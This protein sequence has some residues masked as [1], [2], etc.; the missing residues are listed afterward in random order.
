MQNPTLALS[1]KARAITYTGYALLGVA[2][3]AVQV[4]FAAAEQ[5]QPVWLTVAL[6]VYA[7]VGG[8]V[9]FTA[10]SHTP[11]S[12]APAVHTVYI[13]ESTPTTAANAA[14]AEVRSLY[15]SRDTEGGER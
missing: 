2:L 6:A 5:G 3:G 13:T 15:S 8:A 10:V 7:F 12:D 14:A 9:G 1:P 4:G 11:S